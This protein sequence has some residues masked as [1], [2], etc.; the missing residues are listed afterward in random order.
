MIRFHSKV[1]VI[2][3]FLSAN[4]FAK[5]GEP[6]FLWHDDPKMKKYQSVMYYHEVKNSDTAIIIAPGGSYHHLGLYNEGYCSAQYF[7]EKRVAAFVLR[8]RTAQSGFHHPAMLQDIER[9]IILVKKLG[10]KKIGL[11]GYSAGGHLVTMAALLGCKNNP[12]VK[13]DFVIPVYPVVSMTDEIA[14]KWSR[15]SLLGR[16]QSDERKI[17]YSM[18]KQVK[19]FMPPMYIVVCDDD[20]VVDP[21][22]ALALYEAIKNCGGDVT[23]ARYPWG[24]H[25]FG[26]LNNR[27][28]KEFHWNES[29]WQ[30]IEKKLTGVEY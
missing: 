10:F 16:N 2:L 23:L 1:L 20:P 5:S 17:Q 19:S 22:N 29:L 18:E 3:F 28:N 12:D 6:I 14:H 7:V 25:G 4:I 11:I 24:G 15:N 27:F 30:W 26:M 21:R 9:A 8:Y 13:V